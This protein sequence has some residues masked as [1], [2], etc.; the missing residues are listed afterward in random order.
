[1]LQSEFSQILLSLGSE[2]YIDFNINPDKSYYKADEH[3]DLPALSNGSLD[4]PT[5][6]KRRQSLSIP[7][8]PESRSRGRRVSVPLLSLGT[9]AHKRNFFE[10]VRTRMQLLGGEEMQED[11]DCS[12]LESLDMP[13]GGGVTNGYPNR[14][15]MNLHS[16]GDK[17]E[18]MRG[19]R[20]LQGREKSVGED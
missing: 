8:L 9:N 17:I 3:F 18:S 2:S 19:T 5:K 1:M 13:A 15:V 7:Q 14:Y 10:K 16:S 12:L 20:I 11:S 6:N 4:V